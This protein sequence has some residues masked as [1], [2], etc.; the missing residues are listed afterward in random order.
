MMTMINFKLPSEQIGY[1]WY[2]CKKFASSELGSM[3]L[4]NFS[5]V[6][7]SIHFFILQLVKFYFA[8][9]TF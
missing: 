9:A 3:N 7:T 1:Q 6:Q 8:P 5:R 4:P 2:H